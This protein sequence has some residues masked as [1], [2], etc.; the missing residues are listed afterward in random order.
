VLIIHIILAVFVL[1][2]L[3]LR[4]R[5]VW[6]ATVA[7]L[8][9]MLEVVLGS[10]L[11]PALGRTAP[12]VCFLTAALTIA[13]LAERSGLLLRAALVLAIAG[14]EDARRLYLLVCALCVLLT[15]VVSLDGAV[16]LMTPL[17]L[18]LKR[19]GAP[20]RPLFF[21]VISVANTASICVP[22]GNPTNLVVLERLGM[23]P[24]AFCGHMLLP[25]I[26]ASGVCGAAVAIADRRLLAT[27]YHAPTMPSLPLL[28][29]ERHASLWLGASA[30]VAWAAPLMGIAPWW[31]FCTVATVAVLTRRRRRAVVIPWRIAF[32]L[33]GLLLVVGSLGLSLSAPTQLGLVGLFAVAIGIGVASAC[34]NNLPVSVWS[35]SLLAGSR[36]GYAASLGMAVGSLGAPQGSVA[37]LL[38]SERAG[39][40]APPVHARVF[41]PLALVALLLAT[42]VLW[43]T[44]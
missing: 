22:Q 17:L 18:E 7:I 4:P 11:E 20:F 6:A 26:C 24:L 15:A 30:L 42:I 27:R 29:D 31:P 8:A 41:A 25:G 10:P 1:V 37:T 12:I 34:L 2:V 19:L 13:A 40:E 16:V 5:S 39:S 32:Q 33:T 23:S 38:A 28:G 44:L 3:A 35:A 36:S 21:G 14:K 43:G 9:G